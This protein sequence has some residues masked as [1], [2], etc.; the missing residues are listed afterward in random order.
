MQLRSQFREQQNNA[1]APAGGAAGSTAPAAA[2]SGQAAAPANAAPAAGGLAQ[3][4]GRS[5]AAASPQEEKIKEQRDRLEAVLARRRRRSA[6]A[7]QLAEAMA[8]E[9][10]EAASASRAGAAGQTP[11]RK[12]A[13]S[14]SSLKGALRL[15]AS[16]SGGADAANGSAA[17]GA[18]RNRPRLQ[19]RVVLQPA[20]GAAALI[21]LSSTLAEGLAE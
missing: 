18:L 17:A 3:L 13:L 15:R 16:S 5:L 1:T 2:P 9:A 19:R 12:R 4:D 21:S 11:G 6:A 20:P 14:A 7:A 10:S 8:P